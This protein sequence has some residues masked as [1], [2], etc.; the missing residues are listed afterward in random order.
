MRLAK[1][2]PFLRATRDAQAALLE[3]DKGLL[4]RLV[5]SYRWCG[6]S[7]EDLLQSA[8][9]GYL[10]GIERFDPARGMALATYALWWARQELQ[11][12]ISLDATIQMAPTTVRKYLA[13]VSSD[14]SKPSI[15]DRA[16]KALR[17]RRLKSLD[18]PAPSDAGEST[19]T[20]GHAIACARPGPDEALE[21]EAMLEFVASLVN[22]A[23]A[24]LSPRDRDI[25]L[26][27]LVDDDPPTLEALG[28][29]H[30]LTRE[31]VRQIEVRAR[32]RL[33]ALIEQRCNEEDVAALGLTGTRRAVPRRSTY[34]GLTWTT[35]ARP[36]R[37]TVYTGRI[38]E[39]FSAV[40]VGNFAADQEEQAA[41]AYDAKARELLGDNAKLN[42]PGEG[43]AS[44]A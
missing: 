21:R 6:T 8:S 34:R 22:G 2:D 14:G 29:K 37:V 10:K 5:R 15:R 40:Y 23:F 32:A 1:G 26:R 38:S 9:V 33:L 43:S 41:R 25:A 12:A 4:V 3:A 31:R 24:G 27:R 35:A 42:F 20:I 28:E 44:G 30:N 36:W 18:A 16:R 11:E 13:A 17:L 7:A 39:R 19:T